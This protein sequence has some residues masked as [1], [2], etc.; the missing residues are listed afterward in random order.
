MGLSE[1]QARAKLGDRVGCYRSQ[2]RPLL[3]CLT[4]A[5]EKTFV[6]LVVDRQ[7]SERILG[8]HMVGD[9]AVEIIQ[10]RALAL[11]LGATK[12]DLDRAIGIHPSSGE[13][14][15]ALK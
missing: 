2:F 7:D 3:Y 5:E 14:I 4:G 6:K 9:G 12:Q 8:V 15:F 11:R 1:A 13:E 10:S